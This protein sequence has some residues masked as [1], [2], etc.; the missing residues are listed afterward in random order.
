MTPTQTGIPDRIPVGKGR[1]EGHVTRMNGTGQEIVEG[2][3]PLVMRIYGRS[4]RG[5]AEWNKT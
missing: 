3:Y 1:S 4:V 2:I 5:R